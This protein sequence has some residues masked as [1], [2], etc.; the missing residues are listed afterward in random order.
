MVSYISYCVHCCVQIM[1]IYIHF[2]KRHNKIN[3]VGQSCR[4]LVIK[5]TDI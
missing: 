1:N 4:F 2:N 5:F 3:L